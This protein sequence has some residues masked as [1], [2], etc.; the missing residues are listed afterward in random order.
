[1]DTRSRT[2]EEKL[3]WFGRRSAGV[4][5]RPELLRAEVS[6]TEIWKRVQKG[7]LIPQ[8]PGVYRIG[9]AAPNPDA[10]FVAAVKACGEGACLSGKAAGYLHALLKGKPPPPEITTPT[11]RKV[12]G[13]KTRRT[14]QLDKRDVTRVRGIPVTTVPRTLVDLAATL[15]ADD[16]ARACHEAGV[17]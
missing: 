14:R 7:L 5:T 10:A 4:V 11:E 6:D 12:K 1:M 9:H 2:V 17:R 15:T 13:I 3:A 16:L 8:Y